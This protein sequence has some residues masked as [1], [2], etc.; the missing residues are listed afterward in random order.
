MKFLGDNDWDGC[1]A[2]RIANGDHDRERLDRSYGR[3]ALLVRGIE[4]PPLRINEKKNRLADQGRG[5]PW[6]RNSKLSPGLRMRRSV[7]TPWASSAWLR[8]CGSVSYISQT[9]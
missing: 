2:R 8:S 4:S 9:P 3:N 1:L 5:Q 7:V 6:L